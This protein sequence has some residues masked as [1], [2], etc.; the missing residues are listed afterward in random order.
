MRRAGFEPEDYADDA[1]EVWPEN[2]PAVRLFLSIRS[3]WLP[4]MGKPTALNYVVL[5]HRMDRLKLS[6]DDYEQMFTDV[7][8]VESG[9][10]DEIHKSE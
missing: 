3:Q 8:A 9:A 7:Q 6:D 5:F 10:L 1:Y 4:S 2:W